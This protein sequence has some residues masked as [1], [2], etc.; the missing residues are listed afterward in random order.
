MPHQPVRS[1]QTC[2]LLRQTEEW[3]RGLGPPSLKEPLSKDPTR[4]LKASQGFQGSHAS[5]AFSLKCPESKAE[6]VQ[7]PGSG[8]PLS[9]D[10]VKYWV[11]SPAPL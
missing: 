6:R 2:L 7:T 1:T 4:S 9:R 10:M 5:E 3:E 8:S 11:V